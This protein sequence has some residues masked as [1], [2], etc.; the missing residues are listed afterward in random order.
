M[1][2]SPFISRL[3]SHSWHIPPFS[4]LYTQTTHPQRSRAFNTQPPTLF[5]SS[6]KHR[7]FPPFLQL[8]NYSTLTSSSSSF[9]FLLRLFV[10]TSPSPSAIWPY[11]PPFKLQAQVSPF[12]RV[13]QVEPTLPFVFSVQQG[14]WSSSSF[15]SSYILST[16]IERER[17]VSSTVC[18]SFNRGCPRQR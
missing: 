3:P 6:S 2:S 14:S 9:P 12:L 13:F 5:F 11:L 15:L 10:V 16:S 1:N 7:A 4:H 18:S 17:D 8:T